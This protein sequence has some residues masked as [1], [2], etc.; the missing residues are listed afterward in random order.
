MSENKD[1][2]LN[3]AILESRKQLQKLQE[4]LQ[5][6][7]VDYSTVLQ[8]ISQTSEQ[9]KLETDVISSEKYSSSN[10]LPIAVPKQ[11]KKSGLVE[12]I[13]AVSPK[14]YTPFRST[15]AYELKRKFIK[16]VPASQNKPLPKLTP[17]QKKLPA[18]DLIKLG[19]VNEGD[20]LSQIL[21][22]VTSKMSN[23]NPSLFTG[24]QIDFKGA[25]EVYKM[26]KEKKKREDEELMKQMEL[27]KNT[28]KSDSM[29][30][31]PTP[32]PPLIQQEQNN[33][34][35]QPRI[36]EELQDAFAY[37]TLLVVRGK[38]AR[39]TPDF[40][41]F[42]RT[43]EYRFQSI[44][45]V[46]NAIEG[47]CKIMDIS[48]AEIDGRMLGNVA[49]S[50]KKL[51]Y[52]V[53]EKCLK[54]IDDAV[55]KRK[56]DAANL[57]KKNYRI[58]EEKRLTNTR[59]MLFKAAY[60]IQQAWRMN[61]LRR[62]VL[63]QAREKINSIDSDAFKLS[64][65]LR[66]RY[67]SIETSPY[68]IVHVLTGLQD[69]IR[70]FDLM[71]TNATIIF[72]VVNLPSSHIWE[73]FLEFMACCGIPNVNE[74][75]NYI[76]MRDL[77]SGNNTSNKLLCDMRSIN[78]VRRLI[79][80]RESFIIPHSDWHAERRL[81]VDI[82]CPIFGVVDTDALQ[83]RGG[84]KDLFGEAGIVSPLS[85][86]EH[87]NVNDLVADMRSLM[88]DNR[89]LTRWIIHLGYTPNDDAIAWFDATKEF[90]DDTQDIVAVLKKNL[91]CKQ[92]P[93][94][95]LA[96]IERVGACVEAVPNPVRSFPS[97]ALWITGNEIRVLGTYDRIHHSPFRFGASFLPCVTVD[98]QQLIGAARQVGT[99]LLKHDVIGHATVDFFS[100]NEGN[101][102]IR[103]VG[104][105]IRV[106]SYPHAI[107]TTCTSLCCG[108][109]QS[110]GKFKV[111]KSVGDPYSKNARYALVHN[112]LTHPGMNQFGTKDLKS[113]IYSEGLI[114]DLLMRTGFILL[115]FDSPSEGKNTAIASATSP[116][117]ALALMEKSYTYLL[118][119]L[120]SKVGSD[121]DSTIANALIG[122]R[123]FRTR[124]FENQ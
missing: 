92:T 122:M 28:M 50:D 32:D 37:Q 59:K 67:S 49:D 113:K 77:R 31:N 58:F 85:T 66:N 17:A 120:S 1:D 90:Y 29:V 98:S 30:R 11:K 107:M 86:R 63:N 114:F 4:T 80:N 56:A 75:V 97:V 25:A 9:L 51:T 5:Q 16:Q 44:D 13:R 36:Y 123:H 2:S 108:F 99:V 72:L 102:V 18:M 88:E 64:E 116:D 57:I 22:D 94:K 112:G 78:Q 33:K 3:N 8:Q 41:S 20:D 73:D 61:Q 26:K 96:M 45:N 39:E 76:M 42:Q 7:D 52:D 124:I 14:E 60:T 84:I 69:I 111:L 115:F 103:V 83:S 23:V 40:E 91:H 87:R 19:I 54:G 106:N 105:D 12:Q 62:Q 53:V 34:P 70:I 21:P 121:E 89:D 81:S 101:N 95:F 110:S 6:P 119:A 104:F 27:E 79:A 43:N 117:S 35:S 93:A 47:Y 38:V 68:V 118:K 109:E 10:I 100:Y 71:Y 15:H 74:R 82:G 48:Y 55:N 46:L 24:I 65:T